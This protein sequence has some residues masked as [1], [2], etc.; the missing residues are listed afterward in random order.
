MCVLPAVISRV[1]NSDLCCFMCACANAADY[2]GIV[3]DTA[4]E[5]V[6]VE[7][8]T[9]GQTISV[10]KARIHVVGEVPF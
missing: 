2:Y 1:S 8:H 7:L 4:E 9:R 6:R 5:T 3:K 10:D